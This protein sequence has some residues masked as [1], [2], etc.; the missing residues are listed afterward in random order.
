MTCYH[1]LDA[2]MSVKPQANG[3]RHVTF[4]AKASKDYEY[5]M[6]PCGRCIGCKLDKSKEWAIRCLH[7]ASLYGDNNCFIT[8]TFNEANLNKLGSLVKD[9]FV[10]FMKRFR[11]HYKGVYAVDGED[12]NGNPI[13]T[14]PIRYFHCGEYGDRYSRPH[15]HACIFNFD[16]EDKV[17]LSEKNGVRLYSSEQLERLWSKEI[18]P[19]DYLNY[20]PETLWYDKKGG[21]HAKLG[22]C[23]IGE[24]N[25][26]T[27][28]YVA[29]YAI[30]KL[31][32]DMAAIGYLRNVD[33]KTGELLGAPYY[34]EPEYASM[35]TRPGI[36]KNWFKEF[37]SDV[38]PSDF[39]TNSKGFKQKA[40][41]YYDKILNQVDPDALADYKARRVARA[42]SKP[43]D[44]QSPKRLK[45]MEKVKQAKAKRL[46]RGFENA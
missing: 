9:D 1:P 44:E 35:S 46:K 33:L 25:Y 16:F 23:S 40:P 28:A 43:I 32:G 10:L 7:E 4:I 13:I 22:F 19:Y 3:K 39:I 8:L 12:K 38:Y 20:D 21:L 41:A 15:H 17:L 2:W 29:R 24:L 31:Y 42:K 11:K 27:A 14:Y 30:K 5:T 36:G 18:D 6:L 37:K 34:I 26:D 45:Q